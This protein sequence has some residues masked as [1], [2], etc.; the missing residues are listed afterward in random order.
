MKL[1]KTSE[2]KESWSRHTWYP[3]HVVILVY[4]VSII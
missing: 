4:L 3:V 2:Q 1:E